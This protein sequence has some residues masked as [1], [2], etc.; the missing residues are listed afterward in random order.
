ML[1]CSLLVFIRPRNSSQLPYLH[2]AAYY[3][4]VPDILT[5]PVGLLPGEL[6]A[7]TPVVL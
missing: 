5:A 6:D 1:S 4:V 3:D 2:E 7:V